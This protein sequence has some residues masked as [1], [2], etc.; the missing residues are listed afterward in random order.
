MRIAPIRFQTS[1]NAVRFLVQC[2]HALSWKTTALYCTASM[3]YSCHPDV[4]IGAMS[5]KYSTA[6]TSTGM[7]K[8]LECAI[9]ME[10]SNCFLPLCEILSL[11]RPCLSRRDSDDSKP[12]LLNI[13]KCN[14]AFQMTNQ[15]FKNNHI[16][17][18]DCYH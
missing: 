14:S 4:L 16:S 18:I 2:E 3:D 17:T 11:S 8:L 13:K 10:N 5:H 7:V 9:Q 6:M 1:S 15:L 12:F